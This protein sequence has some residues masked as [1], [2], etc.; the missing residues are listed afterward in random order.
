MTAVIACHFL[1][2]TFQGVFFPSITSIFSKHMHV[3][4]RSLLYA[5]AQSGSQ[6][7]LIF[8]GLL[9]PMIIELYGWSQVF[10]LSGM[11]SVM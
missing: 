6:L 1:I 4:E 5:F 11:F 2:G 9:G 7:G 8:T 3:C 10:V